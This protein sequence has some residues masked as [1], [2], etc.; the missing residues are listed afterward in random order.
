MNFQEALVQLR[1]GK[2]VRRAVWNNDGD[3]GIPLACKLDVESDT[4]EWVD[5]DGDEN[6]AVDFVLADFSATDWEVVPEALPTLTEEQAFLYF[7]PEK[8]R[9]VS[10]T[11]P[12]RHIDR[13]HRV[14]VFELNRAV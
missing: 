7:D 12:Q 14:A 2:I 13:G 11:N 1:E 3:T 10:T 4:I 6:G 9:W 8:A 5:A